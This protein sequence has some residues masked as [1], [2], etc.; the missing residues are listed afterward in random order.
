M[1]TIDK[2]EDMLDLC[3]MTYV[4]GPD[5][6]CKMGYSGACNFFIRVAPQFHSVDDFK[7]FIDDE[8]GKIIDKYG[9]GSDYVRGYIKACKDILNLFK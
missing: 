5:T 4:S 3:N 2:I 8:I 6:D 9:N 1:I 7:A